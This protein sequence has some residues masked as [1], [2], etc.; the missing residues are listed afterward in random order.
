[1]LVFW[2]GRSRVPNEVFRAQ[3]ALAA[4]DLKKEMLWATLRKLELQQ[5]DPGPQDAMKQLIPV[6]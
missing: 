2:Q 6:I 1:M 5:V 4:S 3:K